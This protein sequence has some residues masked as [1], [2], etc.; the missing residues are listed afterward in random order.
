MTGRRYLRQ[1]S[2]SMMACDW[3]RFYPVARLMI[4]DMHNG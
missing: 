2:G 1:L 3:I 4:G